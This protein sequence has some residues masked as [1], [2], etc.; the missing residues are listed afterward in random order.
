MHYINDRSRR[1]IRADDSID[2]LPLRI[3]MA[4]ALREIRAQTAGTVHLRHLG[5]P[6]VMMIVDDAGYAKSLPVNTMATHLYWANCK[7]GTT[8]EI[9]GDVVIAPDSDFDGGA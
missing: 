8:H 6:A 7:P 9:R 1:V 4:E 2:L 3:S 5:T